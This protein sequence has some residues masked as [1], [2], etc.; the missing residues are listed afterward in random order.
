MRPNYPGA[1]LTNLPHPPTQVVTEL[2]IPDD[3]GV[4]FFLS[5]KGNTDIWER[6]PE[7]IATQVSTE[8][9]N[10]PLPYTTTPRPTATP[11]RTSRRTICEI[12]SLLTLITSIAL[13]TISL[14]PYAVYTAIARMDKST[15][16]SFDATLCICRNSVKGPLKFTMPLEMAKRTFKGHEDRH[17]GGIVWQSQIT[18]IKHRNSSKPIQRTL[19]S[20]SA[21]NDSSVQ[22]C[23]RL[24]S[25]APHT[26]CCRNSSTCCR[27]RRSLAAR[28]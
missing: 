27:K 16:G 5:Q 26:A 8:S 19:A 6:T 13:Q 3:Q 15:K 20:S 25:T 17:F 1:R 28:T 2:D 21:R 7:R 23:I 18:L 9:V 12:F 22:I 11:L 10:A 14:P 24:D 4:E